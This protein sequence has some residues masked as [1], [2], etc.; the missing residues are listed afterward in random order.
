MSV[1]ACGC[2]SEYCQQSDL[3]SCQQ[4]NLC[5]SLGNSQGNKA[6]KSKPA[7]KFRVHHLVDHIVPEVI[8]GAKDSSAAITCLQLYRPRP[9]IL[10]FLCLPPSLPHPFHDPLL[11]QSTASSQL[12]HHSK[13]NSIANVMPSDSPVHLVDTSMPG[14]P[15]SVQNNATIWLPSSLPLNLSHH[16]PIASLTFTHSFC[17]FSSFLSKVRYLLIS[18]SKP[19]KP[20][21]FSPSSYR[22]V[23]LVSTNASSL[24]SHLTFVWCCN[25]L[26]LSL[27]SS[28]YKQQFQLF[29]PRGSFQNHVQQLLTDKHILLTL[30]STCIHACQTD[31]DPAATCLKHYQLDPE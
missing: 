27:P 10:Q 15:R 31:I 13:K 21:F 14:I 1:W 28:T 29:T 4:S 26:K 18:P 30:L 23:P 11:L 20:L 19:H 25:S 9:W 22:V 5:Q 17:L 2:A 12:V 16:L 3:E 7:I 8:W 24:H 6:T